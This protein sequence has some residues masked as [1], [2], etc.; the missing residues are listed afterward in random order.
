MKAVQV[1]INVMD[2]FDDNNENE[3]KEEVKKR[4]KQQQQQFLSSD[5]NYQMP[6]YTALSKKKVVKSKKRSQQIQ[7]KKTTMMMT[8]MKQSGGE[9]DATGQVGK[10]NAAQLQAML[11]KPT[12]NFG[13]ASLFKNFVDINQSNQQ[14]QVSKKSWNILSSILS[15][16][17]FSQ[18]RPFLK[19]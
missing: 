5:N 2:F 15:V 17:S 13:L 4:S 11:L 1:K 12:N 7:I 8:V 6:S 10:K 18:F 3:G 16:F 19:F 9:K 14:G